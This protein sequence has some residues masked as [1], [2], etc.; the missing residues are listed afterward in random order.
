MAASRGDEV[1][2]AGQPGAGPDEQN[3]GHAPGLPPPTA[4]ETQP[5]DRA[6]AAP[7]TAPARHS[8]GG[9]PGKA[10]SGQLPPQGPAGA[11][12]R[13]E[14]RDTTPDTPQRAA[15]RETLPG[16]QNRDE[17]SFDAFM[18]YGRSD[19]RADP[20][21]DAPRGYPEPRGNHTE[22]TPPMVSRQAHLQRD[23]T[24]VGM[25][26]AHAATTEDGPAT[27]S[28][29][30]GQTPDKHNIQG[31]RTASTNTAGEPIRQPPGTTPSWGQGHLGYTRSKGN[32]SHPSAHAEQA[33][34]QDMGL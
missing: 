24:A 23:Y 10:A 5:A 13:S 19:P 27:A 32:A 9:A 14:T 1:R 7:L 21:P 33:A 26:I 25:Q 20:A 11:C 6:D 29:A 2:D 30:A 28:G 18:E 34:T 17:D 12:A 4:Q 16:G 8:D 31:S 22:G 15:N 3:A